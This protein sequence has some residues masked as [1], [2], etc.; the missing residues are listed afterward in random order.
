MKIE[1]KRMNEACHMVAKNEDGNEIHIDG[2]AKVGGEG[3]GFRPMQLLAAGA[4]SCSSIDLISI[5]KKQRQPLT[6]LQVNIDAKR[7]EGKVPSLFNTIHL[8]YILK[9]NLDKYK[10]EK[11]L[12]LSLLKYCSVVKIIEKTAN[13]TYSYEIIPGK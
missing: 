6:D 3:K 8:H 2:A 7:E 9:G 13:I 1:L 12:E 5:L 4:G 10:V 11:A